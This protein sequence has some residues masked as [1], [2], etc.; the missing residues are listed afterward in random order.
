MIDLDDLKDEDQQ[1]SHVRKEFILTLFGESDLR[2]SYEE[3]KARHGKVKTAEVI[4]RLL[5]EELP[6]ADRE[7]QAKRKTKCPL[8]S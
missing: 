4:R 7:L 6:K 8:I 5:R 3:F 1:A 2:A